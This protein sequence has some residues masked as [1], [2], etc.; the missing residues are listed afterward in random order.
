[1]FDL[2]DRRLGRAVGGCVYHVTHP[3]GLSYGAFPLNAFEAEARRISRFW[4]FGHT[5]GDAP[6]RRDPP[7]ERFDPDFPTTLD[8]RRLPPS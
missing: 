4:A 5:A 1:V 8:L 6:A 7:P 3:G 2:V